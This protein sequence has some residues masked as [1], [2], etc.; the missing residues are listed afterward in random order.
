[1][2]D[3]LLQQ[4]AGEEITHVV[5]LMAP[6]KAPGEINKTRIILIPK[7]ENP[8]NLSQFR[9]ISLCNIVYEIITKVL[10]NHMGAILGNCINEA[11]GAFIPGRHISDNVLIAY[12]V[13]HSL[14]MKKK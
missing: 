6:M 14:K 5:K 13:F 1:M 12:E 8:K 4:F 2:N 10:V 7:V 11:Q 3:K 9:P